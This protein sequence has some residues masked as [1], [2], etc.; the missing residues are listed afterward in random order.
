MPSTINWSEYN[1]RRKTEVVDF[2][3]TAKHILHLIGPPTPEPPAPEA[4]GRGRPRKSPSSM[5]LV[6]LLRIYLKVSYR[7]LESLLY[8]NHQLRRSLGLDAV[9]GRDTIHRYAQTLSEQYLKKFNEQLVW[10]LKKTRSEPASTLRVC[11]SRGTR[12]VGTLPRT[13][14]GRTRNSG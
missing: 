9:P 2:L 11:R 1:A 14:R 4:R 10:R 12:D 8:S 7:E 6:N 13:E 5:L 3:R